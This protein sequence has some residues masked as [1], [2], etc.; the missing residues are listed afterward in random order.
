M[1][2]RRSQS[3]RVG[4]LRMQTNKNGPIFATL[5]GTVFDTPCGQRK[6]AV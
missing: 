5:K 2:A 1:P 6:I 4:K 3:V